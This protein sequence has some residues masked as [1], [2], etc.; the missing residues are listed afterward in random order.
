MRAQSHLEQKTEHL[1]KE[2]R[3]TLQEA[4]RKRLEESRRAVKRDGGRLKQAVRFILSPI[5]FVGDSWY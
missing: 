3:S 4:S 1:R 5:V 2:K